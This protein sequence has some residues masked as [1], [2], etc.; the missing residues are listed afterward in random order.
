[1]SQ[2]F[3][4]LLL[5]A[6]SLTQK[7]A[8][9]EAEEPQRLLKQKQEAEAEKQAF[10]DQLNKPSDGSDPEGVRRAVRII[11]RAVEKG[12]VSV[13][14]YRFPNLLCTDRG[15]AIN[16][17]EKGWETTLTSEPKEVY[18]LWEKYFRE[19]GYRLK[20]KIVDL[21]DGVSS[22]AALTLMCD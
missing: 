8:L 17:G 22:D 15:R 16:Q 3:T 21:P 19:K 6:K 9:A 1:M 11:G 20:A 12:L 14:V 5:S 4:D 13:Q 7:I 10:I 2:P 18:Q